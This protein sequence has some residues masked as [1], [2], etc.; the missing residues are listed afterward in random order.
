VVVTVEE[1]I[2]APRLPW[3]FFS[4]TVATNGS[5]GKA[6]VSNWNDYASTREL[7]SAL[8]DTV[9]TKKSLTDVNGIRKWAN[10]SL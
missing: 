4:P 3:V 1:G 2:S 8:S 7:L 10:R 9:V 5:A 6:G